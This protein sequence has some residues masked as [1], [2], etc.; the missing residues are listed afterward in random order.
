V[1]GD[2]HV[3]GEIGRKLVDP[4]VAWANAVRLVSPDGAGV[5]VV[6]VAER[7]TSVVENF[8]NTLARVT[9]GPGPVQRCH[10]LGDLA[11]GAGQK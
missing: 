4:A 11:G 3:S 1:L 6:E 8:A 7:G 2:R 5:R 10:H 9:L